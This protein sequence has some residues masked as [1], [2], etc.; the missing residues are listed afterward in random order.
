[1]EPF[2][3]SIESLLVEITRIHFLVFI[4]VYL[5]TVIFYIDCFKILDLGIRVMYQSTPSVA[6]PWG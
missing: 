6:F 5:F 2:K 3:I 4:G 1:M